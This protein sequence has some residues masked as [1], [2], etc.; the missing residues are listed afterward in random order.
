MFGITPIDADVNGENGDGNDDNDDNDDD[1]FDAMVPITPTAD[2]DEVAAA[3][4]EEMRMMQEI[5][6]GELV[7]PMESL[8]VGS[9]GEGAENSTGFA[10]TDD[11]D[12]YTFL[13]PKKLAFT[14]WA[15]PNHWKFRGQKKGTVLSH[16]NTPQHMIVQHNSTQHNT[17][18]HNTT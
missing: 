10:F 1:G 4:S 9:N 16:H 6:G 3:E 8:Q 2:F 11:G 18:Q 13:D 14:N 15:G 12:E 5:E 7:R 17:I